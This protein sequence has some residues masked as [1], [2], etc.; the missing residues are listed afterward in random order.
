[1][2]SPMQAAH[3]ERATR[4]VVDDLTC[5]VFFAGEEMLAAGR[6]IHHIPHG[7]QVRIE[8][9]AE[10]SARQGGL[11]PARGLPE[12]ISPLDIRSVLLSA[13]LCLYLSVG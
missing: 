2:H 7:L 12:R 8:K 6:V 3:F 13:F 11:V 4:I 9:V 5:A 1:M 10:W